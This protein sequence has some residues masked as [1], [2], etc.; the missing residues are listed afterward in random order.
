MAAAR[1]AAARGADPHPPLSSL[2]RMNKS[3]TFMFNLRYRME[4]LLF[5]KLADMVE[6]QAKQ[7]RV[8]S[9]PPEMLEIEAY[10]R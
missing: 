4:M 7:Q 2:N 1:M 8:V 10:R 6:K 9:V 3:E 5:K